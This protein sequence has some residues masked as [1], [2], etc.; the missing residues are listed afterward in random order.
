MLFLAFPASCV[1]VLV[2]MTVLL[3][4]ILAAGDSLFSFPGVLSGRL[5]DG[6]HSLG[7]AS[8]RRSTIFHGISTTPDQL[9]EGNASVRAFS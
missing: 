6:I 3:L 1:K 9:D 4:G 5:K 8:L 7:L 2:V